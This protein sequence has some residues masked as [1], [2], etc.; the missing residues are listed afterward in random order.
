MALLH[1]TD[2]HGSCRAGMCWCQD[3]PLSISLCFPL[4][5]QS[6]ANSQLVTSITS[7]C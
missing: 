3:R 2:R 7:S 4:P 1:L 6:R 5:R